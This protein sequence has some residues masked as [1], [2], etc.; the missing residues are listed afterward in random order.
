MLSQSEQIKLK[1]IENKKIA[2]H[3]AVDY[4]ETQRLST[5]ATI[6]YKKALDTY[7]DLKSLKNT[8]LI[9]LAFDFRREQLRSYQ[10]EHTTELANGRCNVSLGGYHKGEV[11]PKVMPKDLPA[12]SFEKECVV[13]HLDKKNISICPE[14]WRL[15]RKCLDIKGKSLRDGWEGWGVEMNLDLEPL[16]KLL[17]SDKK[18]RELLKQKTVS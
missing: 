8:K 13:C 4:P 7:P 17:K 5:N 10:V 9:L 12:L 11:I 1:Q 3:I 6:K 15:I 2:E 16:I 14:C 18:G